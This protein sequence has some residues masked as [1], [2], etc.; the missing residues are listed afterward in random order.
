MQNE[1]SHALRKDGKILLEAVYQ[2]LPCSDAYYRDLSHTMTTR[3][4][5]FEDMLRM[6]C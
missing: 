1:S 5:G 3:E 2:L 6:H 4:T